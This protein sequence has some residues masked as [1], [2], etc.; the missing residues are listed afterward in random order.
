MP[1]F[2]LFLL[3]NGSKTVKNAKNTQQI[4]HGDKVINSP[5]FLTPK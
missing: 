1:L 3:S 5:V 2:S 4:K